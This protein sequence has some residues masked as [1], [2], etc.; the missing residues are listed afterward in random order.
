MRRFASN[1]SIFILFGIL[2]VGCNAQDVAQKSKD[3]SLVESNWVSPDGP[4]DNSSRSNLSISGNKGKLVWK[5]PETPGGLT[6]FIASDKSVYVVTFDFESKVQA[7]FA[8]LSLE[9]GAVQKVFKFGKGE[10]PCNVYRL[11]NGNI[12][13][14]TKLGGD[15]LMSSTKT[16]LTV[17][18]PTL[19]T[20]VWKNEYPA[21]VAFS[22][23]AHNGSIFMLV[24]RD[25]GYISAISE[26]NG[27]ET[28]VQTSF[29]LSPPVI[30]PENLFFTSDFQSGIVAWDRKFEK[31]AWTIESGMIYPILRTNSTSIF[32][33][34]MTGIV[35]QI[36]AKNGKH[37]FSKKFDDFL[38]IL[39]VSDEDLY[40][41]TTMEL[42]SFDHKSRKENWSLDLAK[43]SSIIVGADD[44]LIVSSEKSIHL[45]DTNK[46][47][48]LWSNDLNAAF[49][50]LGLS[51]DK[52]IL[53]ST[54]TGQILAYE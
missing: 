43:A 32:Y 46:G 18:D 21:T 14:L 37:L 22:A 5:T 38:S 19:K 48:V 42:V 52:K 16:R 17:Y 9:N 45:I 4:F 50:C 8:R 10:F 54:Q 26:V 1:L 12:L 7:S 33:A 34:D 47:I 51:S 31:E 40:V 24:M 53:V 28:F 36:D 25:I 20:E 2:T 11:S 35:N 6:R 27:K 23:S 49:S 44:A 3:M 29:S 13:L 39:G 15:S 30:G 41:A